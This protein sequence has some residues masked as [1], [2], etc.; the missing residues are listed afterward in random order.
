MRYLLPMLLYI[1]LTA[2][3]IADIA[4]HRD[5]EP[6]RLPKVVWVLIVLFAPYVGA[7]AWLIARWSN[8]AQAP[9]SGGNRALSPDD[10]PA[11]KVWLNEQERRRKLGDNSE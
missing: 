4:Q 1:G 6:Y 5:E 2:Y 3:V 11:F 7:M 9:R 8:P 10:D